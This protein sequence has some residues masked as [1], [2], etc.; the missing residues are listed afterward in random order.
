VPE[1]DAGSS[2]WTGERLM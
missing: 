2:R 1:E